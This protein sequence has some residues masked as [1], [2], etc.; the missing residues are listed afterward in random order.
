MDR[1][2][3]C[4]EDPGCYIFLFL[5]MGV[6]MLMHMGMVVDMFAST[7]MDMPVRMRFVLN[8]P[9]ESP[10]EI[11]KTKADEEPGSDVTT[12][13]FYRFQFCDGDTEGDADTSD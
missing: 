9:Y 1:E 7:L 5:S 10:D 12:K 4:K 3:N 2:Q 6:G 8:R 11:Y 13:S